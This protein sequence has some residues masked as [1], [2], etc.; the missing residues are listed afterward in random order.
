MINDTIEVK[1]IDIKEN[2]IKIGIAAPRDIKVFRKEIFDE[3]KK[4]NQLAV[5]SS[6]LN[7]D[8]IGQG[9]KDVL[10]KGKSQMETPP[11]IDLE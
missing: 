8:L 5:S 11:K 1:I 10:A 9:L 7:L 4:E 2:T 6:P 3:I